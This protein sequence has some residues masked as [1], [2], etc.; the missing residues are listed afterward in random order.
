[1][2][3][4]LPS[5]EPRLRARYEKL[6]TEHLHTSEGN[7][8]GSR[9]LPGVNEAFAST[10]AA[11]RFYQNEDVTLAGLIVP[12]Q[13]Q[14]A[15]DLRRLSRRY[16]LVLHDWSRLNYN[17]HTRKLDRR[18]IGTDQ[19][20]E[21]AA[22]LLIGDRGGFPIAP[23]SLALLSAEGWQTT[24]TQAVAPDS[25][26]LELT[27]ATLN[28]LRNLPLGLPLVHIIDREGDSVAHFR[29]WS[30]AGEL[31]LVRANDA[32]R[33]VWEGQTQALQQ[34]AAQVP[35]R[36]SQAVEIAAGV[37]GQL[38]VGE[39]TVTLTRPAFPRS[40]TGKRRW[41]KGAPLSLR[42][43]VCQVRLPDETLVAHWHL[44]S[45]V[46]TTV[47][48]AELAE[49]YYWRWRIES[50]FKLLK[51]HGFQVEA[52]QQENAE[53]IAKRL[54]VAA[55]ACLVV[56]HLQRAQTPETMALRDLLIRLS[57]RQVR[58]GQATAP[59]LLAGLWTFLA[60]IELLEHY[61]LHDLKQ[62][63]R[64]AIPGYS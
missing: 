18:P 60:A 56:W 5:L 20:Y 22:A 54:L 10:Q 36:A 2:D 25:T 33:V 8:A 19:G 38:F 62:M 47:T 64:L 40:A 30:K 43:I 34:V 3:I 35:V 46:P 17:A 23:V 16:G 31:F 51:S 6:V 27:T 1:M 53:K 7:A 49:W 42:L 4:P 39:T 29:Q 26:A 59:A 55:M 32:P 37:I 13:E 57:G 28:E 15:C 11:W 50:W 45:N 44:L 52:W 9:A 21:L 14:A 61:D 12:L 24:L 48:A 63:A 58:R 41:I